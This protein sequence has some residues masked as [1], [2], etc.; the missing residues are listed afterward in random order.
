MAG[1]RGRSFVKFRI[2]IPICDTGHH[3][4]SGGPARTHPVDPKLLT[5]MTVFVVWAV[6]RRLRRNFG[7]QRVQVRRLW[8]RIAVLAA[9][10]VLMLASSWRDPRTLEALLGGLAAGGILS[11]YGLKHTQFE[12]NSEGRFYTP[13]TYI[14][15]I[16]TGLFLSRLVYRLAFLYQASSPLPA[17]SADPVSVYNRSP[18]T[19]AVFGILIAYYVPYYL[20]ILHRSRETAVPA[21]A[22]ARQ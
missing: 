19:L 17:G 16:V 12:A 5:L 6:Y 7:R 21:E 2:Q 13:H 1:K 10:G 15:V 11:Y 3:A 22:P 14:G 20:G 8:F 4:A 9:V 18:L